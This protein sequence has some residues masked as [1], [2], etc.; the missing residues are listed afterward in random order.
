MWIAPPSHPTS[1]VGR[2]SDAAVRASV[3]G[4][5]CG[6]VGDPSAAKIKSNGFSHEKQAS[7]DILNPKK[8]SQVLSESLA[9]SH[10]DG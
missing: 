2:A 10:L 7:S 4:A 1:A 3:A 9:E 8:K 5:V 6:N